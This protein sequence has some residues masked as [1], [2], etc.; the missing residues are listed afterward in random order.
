MCSLRQPAPGHNGV[1]VHS[2]EVTCLRGSMGNC[3]RR[4]MKR[5]NFLLAGRE[6]GG[7]YN[8]M[9]F[10]RKTLHAADRG[11]PARVVRA[12]GRQTEGEPLSR[13]HRSQVSGMQPQAW[14]GWGWGE[15]SVTLRL[16][17]KRTAV[18]PSLLPSSRPS[19]EGAHSPCGSRHLGPRAC[20]SPG[21]L[22]PG[23]QGSLPS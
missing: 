2:S 9:L 13:L 15:P 5:R 20:V 18:F 6:R 1:F 7:Q 19:E 8:F 23:P 21:S 22:V 17:R 16:E 11:Q 12:R 10:F 4:V 14:V 3:E